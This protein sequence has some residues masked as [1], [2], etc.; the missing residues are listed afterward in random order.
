MTKMENY[1]TGG[2]GQTLTCPHCG[3]VTNGA[4]LGPCW[5]Y[6]EQ[7]LRCFI[8]GYRAYQSSGQPRMKAHIPRIWQ[9]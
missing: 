8:C 9:S 2:Q 4:T 6:S 3:T 5:D 7:C 1:E